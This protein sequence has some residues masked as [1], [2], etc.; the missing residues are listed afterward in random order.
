MGG[1]RKGFE[2]ARNSRDIQRKLKKVYVN[3]RL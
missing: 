2:S 3:K 1:E